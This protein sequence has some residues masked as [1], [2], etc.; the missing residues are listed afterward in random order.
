MSLNT[1]T[2]PFVPPSYTGSTLTACSPSL[3]SAK[4]IRLS[5]T[6]ATGISSPLARGWAAVH[7]SSTPK[8]THNPEVRKISLKLCQLPIPLP[9]KLVPSHTHPRGLGCESWSIPWGC[10]GVQRRG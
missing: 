6:S 7:G 2:V 5:Q 4:G 1:N 10:G 8:F 3:S 9:P